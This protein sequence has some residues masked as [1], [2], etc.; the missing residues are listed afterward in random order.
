MASSQRLLDHL[1]DSSEELAASADL[2]IT[3]LGC[4]LPLHSSVLAAGSRVLRQA[5]VG[6]AAAGGAASK[7]AAVQQAFSGHPVADVR[8]LLKLLYSSWAGA[9]SVAQADALKG[10]VELAD[11]LDAPV[12]LQGCETRL[13]E[14]LQSRTTSASYT[15]FASSSTDEHDWADWLL[16]ADRFSLRASTLSSKLPHCIF[17]AV[18]YQVTNP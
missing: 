4:Q 9:D 5:L 8:L 18:P 17:P 11:K 1:P 13:L 12:V 15:S 6:A 3:L 16:L 14:L 7:V 10:V 2:I